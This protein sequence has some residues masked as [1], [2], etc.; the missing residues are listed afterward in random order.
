MLSSEEI[1]QKQPASS[2]KVGGKREKHVLVTPRTEENNQEMRTRVA[3]AL[4]MACL[5]LG[6]VVF[7]FV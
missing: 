7:E 1:G 4:T 3:G 2:P 5:E 6:A